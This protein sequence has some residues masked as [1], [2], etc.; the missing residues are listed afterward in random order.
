MVRF[1]FFRLPRLG[2]KAAAVVLAWAFVLGLLA[3]CSASAGCWELLSA[4]R[5]SLAQSAGISAFV[6][7]ALP[8]LISGFAVY[9]GKPL[10][11]IPAAFWKA[12]FFSGVGFGISSVWGSA[13]C[14]VGILALFGSLCSMPVLWW[15]WLRHIGGEAFSVRSFLPAL[16][17]S[18]LI[19]WMD[20]LVISP[21]L[22]KILI[23]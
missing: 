2:C 14:L 5:D 20:I 1:H 22:T 23:F 19:G 13:G 7:T 6:P 18:I 11:L 12:F 21:F 16:A 15:Y 4:S 3:G 9:I 10:L 8:V 17:A